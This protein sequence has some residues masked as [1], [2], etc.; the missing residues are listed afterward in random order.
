MA[1]PYRTAYHFQPLKNWMNDPNGP[2]IYKGI[3]HLFYQY[4]PESAKWANIA[5]GH[6]TSTDL[7]NWT[8]HPPALL[9]SD[10][11]DFN[12]CW[13]GST[14]ILQ[15]GTPA[16]LYTGCVSQKVNL[17]NLAVPKDPLDPYLVE[18][19]KSPHNPI[20]TPNEDEK[21]WFRDPTTAWLGTDRIWRVI[22]GNK[23]ENRGTTLLYKSGDF[24]HWTEAERPLHSSNETTMWECPDFFPVSIDGENGLDTS[25]IFP[26]IKHVLKISAMSSFV[27]Y[28]T[29]GVYDHHNDVYT[30][31]EGSVDNESG[32]RLDYGRYY[33]SK[34]FFD[35]EKKRR[36]F[37][38]WVNES[39]SK[40][41]DLIKGWSGLQCFPRKIWL[42]RGGKQLIQWPV[43]EIEMLRTNK[44]DLQ[45]ITLEAGSKREISGVTAVQADVEISFS[46]PIAVLE[47]AEVL[48]S[49]W[50]NPQEIAN[51]SGS[52]AN[53]GVGPFGLLVL[54]SNNIEEYTAI[55]FRIFKKNDKFV[56][57]MGCDQKRSSV[58]LEYDKTN[59]GAFLDIDPLTEKLSLRTLID[60]SIVESFGGG[61]KTCITTRAY[62]TL[63]INDNAHLFVF[64]N[65]SQHVDISTLNAW[66]L[67]QAYIN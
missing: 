34:S 13:S 62:P 11:F 9:P 53:T 23:R 1:Q 33:A 40:E 12:G 37:I 44:V 41:I 32:L 52:S 8:I 63:A 21:I 18:W 47:Q 25:E 49:S 30:P 39:T 66:S 42:D 51:K 46:I 17:Q 56:A 38:A 59:Y 24:I 14:T 36:I 3:Y 43:E 6:S 64:N 20:M 57:L 22:I 26:G 19:I 60:H 54:A 27:D 55:F 5:W 45:N 67:N 48:E 7:V 61:G 50:T 35:S 65:G 2:M 29:V 4:N 31:D 15:D 58:G 16:I 10:P 28:Y